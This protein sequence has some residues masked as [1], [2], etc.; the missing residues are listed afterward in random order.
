VWAEFEPDE[1]RRDL[2]ACLA[3][4]I[5]RLPPIYSQALELAELKRVSQV[6]AAA[7]LGLS[8]SGMKARVQRARRQLRELVLACHIRRDLGQGRRAAAS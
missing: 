4:M 6:E 2:A 8:V 1:R 5:E 7:F 3:P